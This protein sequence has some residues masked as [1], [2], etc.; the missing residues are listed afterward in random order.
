MRFVKRILRILT[1]K[2]CIYGDFGK[3]NH[4]S[5]GVLV[6]E[7]SLIGNYNYFSPYAILNNAKIENY[8]SIG[9]GARIGLGEHN[10]KAISTFP[11]INNGQD[12]MKL[13]DVDNPTVLGSD[14]WIG[15][16][17]VV[18]QGVKIGT[19]AVIG[20]GAVVT[21]DIPEYAVAVG[22]PARVMKYRFKP[23]IIEEILNTRW[24]DYPKDQSRRIVSRLER[25]MK[26]KCQKT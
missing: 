5:Q 11:A 9:P 3:C 18:L 16:N 12:R 4:F 23:E 14:V 1:G 7:N 19:G 17:A 22:V 24:F 21:K 20:A 2:K 25:E 8:C 15:A 10:I 13:F 6:Y 26:E